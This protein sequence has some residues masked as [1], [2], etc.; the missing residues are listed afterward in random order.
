MLRTTRLWPAALVLAATALLSPAAVQAQTSKLLPAD[1]EMVFTLNLRQILDSPLMKKYG[2]EHAKAGFDAFLQANDDAKKAF[3]GL[4]LDPFKD[5]DRLISTGTST[6]KERGIGII[7]GRFNP[8]RWKTVAAEAAKANGDFLKIS[9]LGAHD[10]WEVSIPGAPQ[11]FFVLMPDAKTILF[12]ARKDSLEEALAQLAGTKTATLKKEVR[13]LLANKAIGSNSKQSM[14]I[15][16]LTAAIVKALQESPIPIPNSEVFM[17][18][19]EKMAPEV[20]GVGFNI[21]VEKDVKFVVGLNAK[22]AQKAKELSGF[23]APALVGLGVMAAQAAQN[24]E[25]LAPL[26]DLV[27]SLRVTVEGTTVIIRGTITEALIE[28]TIKNAGGR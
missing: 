9:K 1:T 25:K 24:D 8:S 17:P 6:D 15:V 13:T 4:G 11:N 20:P 23:A 14:N 26:V 5:I 3:D 18:Q 27:Q 19:L 2:L 22:N 21:T 16:A 28:K 10:L 7:E 12:A